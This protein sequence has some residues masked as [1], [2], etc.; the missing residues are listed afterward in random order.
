MVSHCHSVTSL[1]CCDTSIFQFLICRWYQW[2]P[3]KNEDIIK[4]KLKPSEKVLDELEDIG[5]QL[6]VTFS[7]DGSLL[8]VGG[9]VEEPI[10]NLPHFFSQIFTIKSSFNYMDCDSIQYMMQ[11]RMVN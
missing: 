11:N 4:L 8:A 1:F 3:I 10:L 5:Q 6:A 2:D 7:H 9:E